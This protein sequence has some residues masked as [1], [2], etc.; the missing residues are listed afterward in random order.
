MKILHLLK[1]STGATWALRQM[2]VLQKCGVT[3]HVALP[4]DGPLIPQYKE[5]GIITHSAQL[6]FPVRKPWL[7]PETKNSLM[8]IITEVQ[9]D[10]IHSHFVGT[11]LTMRMALRNDTSIARIYQV[12]GPLHL[13]HWFTR[14]WE[15]NS[16]GPPDFWIGSSRC[17][18]DWYHKSNIPKEKLFLS[19]YGFETQRTVKFNKG[20]LRN[21][22]QATDKDIIIGNINW[23]YA[24]KYYLGQF[25][26][27]KCHE[28]IIE[29]LGEVIRQHPNVLGVFVGGAWGG[30]ISYEEKLQQKARKIAGD[31]IRFTGPLP[32]TNACTAWGDF[33]L[34]VHVPLSEN[35][36]GVV[37]PL[38]MGIPVIASE[39]GGLPEVV[40]E[41]KTGWLVPPRKPKMLTEA[42]ENALNNLERGRQM[43]QTGKKL[44]DSMFN[45]ERTGQEIYH[46]Y[47]YLL[48][49][50]TTPPEPFNSYEFIENTCEA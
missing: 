41:G 15:I 26:G 13:E 28:D 23:M 3:V 45:I 6:D 43:A 31:R 29:A 32:S 35:C 42:I 25:V 33:D 47:Q 40:I 17:I 20:W 9:P 36:G 38:N 8:R 24:P 21:I 27:L 18:L 4:P 39:V 22:V 48:K 37:E 5:A 1:T 44:V 30:A 49:Q 19:Y 16:A 12:A 7:W 50:T 11:T 14:R 2:Q 46:I 34:G 10:I